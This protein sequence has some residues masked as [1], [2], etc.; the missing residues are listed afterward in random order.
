MRDKLGSARLLV[1]LAGAILFSLV[2]AFSAAPVARADSALD[3]L[4]VTQLASPPQAYKVPGQLVAQ[5]TGINVV[6]SDPAPVPQNPPF[7]PNVQVWS[8]T[9]EQSRPSTVV[10]PIDNYIYI[11][12]Q[13]NNG[14]DWDVYLSRS[15]DNGATWATPVAIANSA[16]NEFN[17]SLTVT[18]QGTFILAFQQDGAPDSLAFSHSFDGASWSGWTLNINAVIPE[19][20]QVEFPTVISQRVPGNYP[21]GIMFQ[22]QVWCNDAANCG[23]GAHNA[24]WVGEANAGASD[25]GGWTFGL[26]GSYWL[27]DPDPTGSRMID[28][29]HPSA[30]WGS[31]DY[32]QE[33]D[34]ETIDGAE[35][36]MLWIIISEDGTSP[37]AGWSTTALSDDAIYGGGASDGQTAIVAGTFRLSS[38]PTR[39]QI[40]YFYTDD[41]WATP[42]GALLDSA[43]TDQRALSVAGVGQD[44]HIVYYSDTIVRD[45][46]SDDGGASMLQQ[47]VSDNAGTGVNDF[48]ATSVYMD[49]SGSPRVAWQD[50]RDTDVNIYTTG[51]I[52]YQINIDATCGGTPFGAAILI[53]SITYVNA[54]Q[55]YQW[56]QGSTHDVMVTPTTQPVGPCKQCV[57][58]DWWD[59]TSSTTSPTY[60]LTVSGPM[61]LTARFDDLYRVQIITTPLTNLEVT[62]GTT[63]GPAPLTSYEPPG[64][65]NIAAT[66]PQPPGAT[67]TRYVFQQWNGSVTGSA[68]PTTVTVTNDCANITAE[69]GTEHY[70]TLATNPPGLTVGYDT[71]PSAA[72]F[73]GLEGQTYM[74]I[75]YWPQ[76]GTPPTDVRYRFTGWA[77]GPTTWGWNITVG[78]GPTTYTA[79]FVTQYRIQIRSN[80]DP[81]PDLDTDINPDWCNP[82]PPAQGPIE[83]WADENSNPSLIISTPQTA[84]NGCTYAFTQWA[85]GNTQ[86]MRPIGPVIEPKTYMSMWDSQCPLVMALDASCYSSTSVP[87]TLTPPVGTTYQDVGVP[88]PI[89]WAP[90]TGMPTGETMTFKEWVGVGNGS[91]TGPGASQSITLGGP[92]TQTAFCYHRAEIVV[93]TS[94]SGVGISF[95]V[96][97]TSYSSQTPFSWEFGTTHWLNISE[98]TQT[99]GSSRY[100][101][102]RWVGQPLGQQNISVTVSGPATYTA[103]FN[104]QHYVTV[105]PLN[106]GNPVCDVADCWYDEG[107]TAQIS[108]TDPYPT[109]AQYI[110]YDFLAWSGSSTSTNNPVSIQV[111]APKTLTANWQTMYKATVTTARG[112]YTCSPDS[113]CWFNKDSTASI[114]VTTPTDE[115]TNDNRYVFS[116]WSGDATGSSNPLSL[117]MNSPKNITI[118]WTQQFWLTVNSMCGSTACG[119]PVGGGAWYNSGTIATV[120]VTTPADVSGKTYEFKEWT[121][122]AS[123]SDNPVSVTMDAAKTI[124]A[125]WEEKQMGIGLE[126]WLILIIIIIVVVVLIAL[127]MLKRKKP[128]PIEEEPLSPEEMEAPPPSGPTTPPPPKK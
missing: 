68:N 105:G 21:D 88:V 9:N 93:D 80:R 122:D 51:F 5:R 69:F 61:N 107:A 4:G 23:G 41:G 76:P 46:Y 119:S 101:F 49:A 8:D 125:T 34:E 89:D 43:T 40:I 96:D 72:G 35:W 77:T 111:D 121:G 63:T 75:T 116:A 48:R 62:I 53:D 6:L 92:V 91:Y 26:G 17:P 42:N 59:G 60:T 117:V 33:L 16:A 118:G 115:V 28:P 44:F 36:H 71:T 15:T 52:T 45:Q 104:T 112:T 2:L 57:F 108:V 127:L 124:T 74:L 94:P 113:T 109:G 110:R 37:S 87:S 81:G 20:S 1:F 114:S 56:A 73:W 58:V 78:T 95:D 123:G 128:T 27:V 14:A 99:F 29:L 19:L 83:C 66:T 106:I 38:A 54:P 12:F 50:D 102:V 10:N 7:G 65:V 32:C 98:T 22:M 120:T 18:S 97:G 47:T 25:P 85:D 103:N 100:V 84:P 90:P 86:L 82:R 67:T 64:P 30:W 39:H 70:V 24:F 13:H 11:A 55:T 126:V 79:N 31:A 3:P